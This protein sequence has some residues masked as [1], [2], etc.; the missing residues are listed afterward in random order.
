[1]AGIIR[2]TIGILGQAAFVGVALLEEHL[3]TIGSGRSNGELL[4]DLRDA[5]DRGAELAL[6][7]AALEDQCTE[8]R[9]MLAQSPQASHFGEDILKQIHGGG[10]FEIVNPNPTFPEGHGKCPTHDCEELENDNTP[11]GQCMKCIDKCYADAENNS[12]IPF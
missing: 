12:D 3:D 1:M 11:T 6:R 9:C 8:Y 4:A 7:V 5:R 10:T 2:R